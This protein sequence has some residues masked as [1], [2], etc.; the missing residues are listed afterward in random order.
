MDKH[1]IKK[2]FKLESIRTTVSK[3]TQNITTKFSATRQTRN[4][5]VSNNSTD[6]IEE[7]LLC[8]SSGK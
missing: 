7:D 6:Y 1:F 2:T 4:T 3:H 8:E 5:S